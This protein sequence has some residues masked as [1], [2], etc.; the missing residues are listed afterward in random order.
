[1]HPHFVHS[2][3]FKESCSKGARIQLEFVQ[4]L[5]HTEIVMN[6]VTFMFV[7][8]LQSHHRHDHRFSKWSQKLV[9]WGIPR[10]WH[11]IQS[12]IKI[13]VRPFLYSAVRNK[14]MEYEEY[15]SLGEFLSSE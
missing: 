1:M 12:T 10:F 8:L 13:V 14:S 9:F 11:L 6:N 4:K 15:W 2:K 5:F 7:D 3:K